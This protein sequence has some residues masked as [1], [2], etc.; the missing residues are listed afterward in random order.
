MK[1]GRR[2]IEC[3][4]RFLEAGRFTPTR[5]GEPWS[6]MKSL[7]NR[8]LMWSRKSAEIHWNLGLIKSRSWPVR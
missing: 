1:P 7:I 4:E 2:Q 5:K 8:G 3:L 6:E